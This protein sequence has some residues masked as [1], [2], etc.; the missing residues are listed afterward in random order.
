M[1]GSGI[2]NKYS[3]MLRRNNN[4]YVILLVL[5]YSYL[6]LIHIV[7]LIIPNIVLLSSYIAVHVNLPVT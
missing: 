4:E 7:N 5:S 2:H 6:S 3:V 1:L